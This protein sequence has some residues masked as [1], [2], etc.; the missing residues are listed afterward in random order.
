ME[1]S[2]RLAFYTVAS[3]R[4][5]SACALVNVTKVPAVDGY[6]STFGSTVDDLIST[7][8]EVCSNDVTRRTKHYLTTIEVD[9]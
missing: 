2:R 7:F 6:Y 5:F 8:G 4:Y 3:L 1:M 9:N